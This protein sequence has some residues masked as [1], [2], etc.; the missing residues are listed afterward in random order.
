MKRL[1]F[2]AALFGIGAAKANA[3]DFR[4]PW[5]SAQWGRKHTKP[6]NGECPLCGT[7]A[8]AFKPG[9]VIDPCHMPTDGKV[10]L[11][12][13]VPKDVTPTSRRIDCAHCGLTFKQ[14]AEHVKR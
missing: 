1:S 4:M 8:E 11:T 9:I 6:K 3:Q 10:T 5:Y 12:I 13:C 7:M 14:D 2:L